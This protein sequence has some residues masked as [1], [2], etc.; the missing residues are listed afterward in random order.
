MLLVAPELLEE[1]VLNAS[2]INRAQI[3]AGMQVLVQTELANAVAEDLQSQTGARTAGTLAELNYRLLIEDRNKRFAR[4]AGRHA[5]PSGPH[6]GEHQGR[7][8]ESFSFLQTQAAMIQHC[9]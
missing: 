1:V 4:Q 6:Q 3:A 9:N 5:L 8:K 2:S 7:V